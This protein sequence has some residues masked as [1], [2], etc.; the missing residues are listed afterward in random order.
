LKNYTLADEL[1]VSFGKG[2]SIITGETGAG[3]SVII[4]AL[5]LLV[6]ERASPD[7]IRTGQMKAII[8]ATFDISKLAD[9]K[10]WLRK[11]EFDEADEL[12]IRRELSKQSA[13]RAFINDSPATLSSLKEIGDLLIDL[14]GQHEHQSLLQPE[15]HRSF[16]DNYAAVDKELSSYSS[17]YDEYTKLQK[18]I[19]ELSRQKDSST[20]ERDFLDFQRTEISA[21][22]PLEGE[23]EKIDAELKILENAEELASLASELHTNLIEDAGSIYSRLTDAKVTLEKL[24][25]IDSRF[26]DSLVEVTTMI[27]VVKELS[28]ESSNY[29]ENVEFNPAR[30]SELRNRGMALTRIKKKYGPTLSDVISLYKELESKLGPEGNIDEI[31]Q[32]R[33]EE[34]VRVRK[35]LSLLAQK[36]TDKRKKA[37]EKF[38]KEIL[39]TLKELGMEQSQFKVSVEQTLSS[40]EGKPFVDV[41]KQKLLAYSHGIDSIEFFISNNNGE[42]PKPLARVASGGE[43]SRVMLAMKSAL[44]AADAIPVLVFDE[45]DTGISGR[46]AQKVG[47][48]MKELSRD[49]Q[50]LSI[51]HLSQIAAFADTHY[52]VEKA[53]TKN[54]TTTA[55]R[56]L[57]EHEH[58]EEVARLIAGETVTKESL[59]AAKAL[60]AE[61]KELAAG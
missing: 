34:L 36:L 6:G 53:T 55:I 44:S 23:D 12:I 59:V 46:I 39:I 20:K 13:A 37:A 26:S 35:E 42:E 28:N 9:V 54:S 18:E 11:N 60:K 4:G 33:K 49:H 10:K 48:A 19:A 32:T 16:L 3:K 8:E 22:N 38:E 1:T 27:S 61:A 15:R 7:L 31:I 47:K 24:A 51:T 45:I 21:I 14:H 2:L 40:D 41:E 56:T 29:S 5:N 57:G 30:L 58:I 50:I 17:K 52:L 25:K 43:I